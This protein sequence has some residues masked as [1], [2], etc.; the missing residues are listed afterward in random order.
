MYLS[1][2]IYLYLYPPPLPHPLTHVN[3]TDKE[4]EVDRVE[5]KTHQSVTGAA[6]RKGSGEKGAREGGGVKRWGGEAGGG[7]GGGRERRRG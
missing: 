6:F 3:R 4:E 1:L 7:R 2:S 5:G